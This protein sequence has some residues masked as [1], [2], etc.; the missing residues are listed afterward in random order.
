MHSTTSCVVRTQN[1]ICEM[2][3]QLLEYVNQIEKQVGEGKE[4]RVFSAYRSPS[5]NKLLIN[6]GHGAGTQEFSY[7]RTS[8]RLFDSRSAAFTGTTSCI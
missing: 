5:Y 8:A 1:Q 4:I 2:D 6:Q 3:I 7:D